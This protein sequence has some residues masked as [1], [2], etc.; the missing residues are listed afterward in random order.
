MRPLSVFGLILSLA[1]MLGAGAQFSPCAAQ[2]AP[3]AAADP[4]DATDPNRPPTMEELKQGWGPLAFMIGEWSGAGMGGG[5]TTA[6]V[7]LQPEL[8]GNILVRRQSASMQNGGTHKDLMI[9]YKTRD[10]KYRASYFDNELHVIQYAVTPITDP[11]AGATFL[12]DEV[13]GMPRFRITYTLTDPKM[14]KIVFEIKSG[15]AADFKTYAEG[16]ATRK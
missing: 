3:A 7:S 13:T 11:V 16:T 6:T 2:N 12:S 10:G 15:G 5:I 14:E 8:D 1:A 4:V 9:I